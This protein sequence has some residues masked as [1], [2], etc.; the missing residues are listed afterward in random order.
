MTILSEPKLILRDPDLAETRDGIH[1]LVWGDLGQWLVMDDELEALLRGFDGTRTTEELFREH[2]KKWG[3]TPENVETEARPLVRELSAR[4]VLAAV[5][6]RN[7]PR[8]EP[9]SIANVTFNITNRCNLRCPFC[10]NAERKGEE[11]PIDQVVGF[12]RSGMQSLSKDAS[13]I[14]LGGEPLLVPERLIPLVE[15]AGEIF[16]RSPMIST[17]GTRLDGEMVARLANIPIEVQVSLDSAHEEIHDRGRGKGV[18]RRAV[19]GIHRLVKKGVYTIVSMVIQRETVKEMEDL[20]ALAR[21]LGVNEARFIPLRNVGAAATS[22]T[23]VTELPDFLLGFQQLLS[24]LDRHP[25][26]GELLARDYFSI[27]AV[28]CRHSASRVSCGIGRRVIFIDADGTLY[29]CPNHVNDLFKLGHVAE[30]PLAEVLAAPDRMG[31]I[32]ALYH[33]DRYPECAAC[34]FKRWCAGDCRGEVLAT[35]GN[36][37]APSPH[38]E[39]LKQMYTEILWRLATGDAHVGGLLR[40]PSVHN[41]GNTYL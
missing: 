10:Y 3:D 33:I 19:A 23:V 35:T 12:L 39:A 40:G 4:G 8:E 5:G 18:H 36:P 11:I 34:P 27:A 1:L 13:L 2:A 9:L 37:L 16:Q 14:I 20:L 30:D 21:D 22:R 31:R 41:A 26:Y 32:R 28:Q 17:N 7:I 6:E 38:C 15:G 29:P 25:E 24:I